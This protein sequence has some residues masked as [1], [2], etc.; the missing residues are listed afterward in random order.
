MTHQRPQLRLSLLFVSVFLLAACEPKDRRPGL[1]LSGELA[2][3]PPAIPRSPL[4]MG[5]NR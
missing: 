1:W 5:V 3:D 4:P 2:A